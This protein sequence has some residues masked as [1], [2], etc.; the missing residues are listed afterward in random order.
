MQVGISRLFLMLVVA[1][2]P[3]SGLAQGVLD[4]EIRNGY[5]LVVDSNV[6]APS[7]YAPGSAYIGARICNTG[8]ATLDNVFAHVGDFGGLTPGI[9]PTSTFSNPRSIHERSNRPK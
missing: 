9:F 5:N 7:T 4:I 3:L 6:T 2:V 1:L 8:D